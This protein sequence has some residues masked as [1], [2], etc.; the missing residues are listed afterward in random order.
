[1]ANDL[2]YD[3]KPNHTGEYTRHGPKPG[4]GANSLIIDDGDGT[5]FTSDGSSGAGR[6][7]APAGQYGQADRS[8]YNSLNGVVGKSKKD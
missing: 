1:M 3:R 2:R 8:K 5:S 4:P 7:K 6:G